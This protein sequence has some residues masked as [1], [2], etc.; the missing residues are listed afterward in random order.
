MGFDLAGECRTTAET[1]ELKFGIDIRFECDELAPVE[2]MHV[3]L[4]RP[5]CAKTLEIE[6]IR[7]D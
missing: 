5:E 7:R 3:I 1:A 4:E 6:E 2:E